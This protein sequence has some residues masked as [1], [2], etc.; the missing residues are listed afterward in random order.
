M[1]VA[2]TFLL[3]VVTGVIL[4]VVFGTKEKKLQHNMTLCQSRVGCEAFAGVPVDVDGLEFKQAV[5]E[6][7]KNVTSSP[8][9]SRISCW[10][11]SQVTNMSLAISYFSENIDFYDQDLDDD[12]Y[13]SFN[14]PLD[15]WDTS[16]GMFQGALSFN[17]DIGSWNVS[18]VTNM[19]NM[20]YG[21]E[22]LTKTLDLG[23][24]PM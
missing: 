7:M 22:A 8:Y 13:K 16:S 3:L 14:E 4:G 21:A 1:M 10:D 9:G 18:S 5:K 20:F 2:A 6:Y 24:C 17:Q 11:V 23:M 12:R 19:S 15:C